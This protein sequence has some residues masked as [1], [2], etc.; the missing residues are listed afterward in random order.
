MRNWHV[1]SQR[2]ESTC[3]LSVSHT[4]SCACEIDMLHH[5]CGHARVV[6]FIHNAMGCVCEIDMLRHR[7]VWGHALVCFTQSGNKISTACETDTCASH[8]Y[9]SH[10]LVFCIVCNTARAPCPQSSQPRVTSVMT[11]NFTSDSL[12]AN[13]ALLWPFVTRLCRL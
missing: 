9:T 13:V 2:C 11:I 7:H 10:R 12:S 8:V 4:I 5:R 1:T 6:C 3:A